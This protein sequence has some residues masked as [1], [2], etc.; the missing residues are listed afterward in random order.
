MNWKKWCNKMRKSSKGVWS[1][2]NDVCDKDYADSSDDHSFIWSYM[3]T[4]YRSDQLQLLPFRQSDFLKICANISCCLISHVINFCCL[5]GAS[6]VAVKMAEWCVLF[7]NQ[8]LSIKDQLRPI[9]LLP[10]V[11]KVLHVKNILWI[12]ILRVCF[13]MLTIVL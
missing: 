11:R 10:A 1:V 6:F 8:Y 12:Y 9:S 2:V 4:C 5:S 3:C 13:V 7:W